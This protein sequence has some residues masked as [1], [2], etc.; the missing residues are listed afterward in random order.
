MTL[1]RN[2]R[3]LAVLVILVV[4]GLGL[5]PRPAR[6][7]SCPSASCGPNVTSCHLCSH[8]IRFRCYSCYDL[9]QKSRCSFCTF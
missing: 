1:L 6:A 2:L 9:D 3:N 7:Q 4:A 5:T 8:S